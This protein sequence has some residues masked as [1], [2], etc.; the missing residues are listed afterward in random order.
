MGIDNPNVVDAISNAKDGSRIALTIFDGGDWPD[1]G[2]HLLALQAKVNTY[3]NFVQ[4][5]QLFQQ[6]PAAQRTPVVIQ[7][8]FREQPS[9]KA[10]QLIDRADRVSRQLGLEVRYEV[11]PFGQR[12][13]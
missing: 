6:Y 11:D 7:V 12:P 2:A 4:S 1:E 5:G 3:F 13:E 8:L 10:R 9:D